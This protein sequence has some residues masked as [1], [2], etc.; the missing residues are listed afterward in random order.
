MEFSFSRFS[1]RS[2]SLSLHCFIITLLREGYIGE[3]CDKRWVFHLKSS[4]LYREFHTSIGPQERP[5]TQKK[6]K[7]KG[8][9]GKRLSWRLCHE[10]I[11]T[12][13]FRKKKQKTNPGQCSA[14][15][16]RNRCH[17]SIAIRFQVTFR[18]C[19]RAACAKSGKSL[20]AKGEQEGKR[21]KKK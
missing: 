11:R 2:L 6:T 14:R 5:P 21:E 1:F 4:L 19:K 13:L 7:T 3:S 20:S 18:F 12:A 9:W 8:K 16:L 15:V 17:S 10:E